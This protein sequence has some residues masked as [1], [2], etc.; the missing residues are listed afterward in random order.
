MGGKNICGYLSIWNI[1]QRLEEY[2]IFNKLN[3]IKNLQQLTIHKK[4]AKIH[5]KVHTLNPTCI[6]SRLDPTHNIKLIRRINILLRPSIYPELS[7]RAQTRLFLL[8]YSKPIDIPQ[9][10]SMGRWVPSECH[11]ALWERYCHWCSAELDEQGWYFWVD[12]QR[13]NQGELDQFYDAW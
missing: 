9:I 6:K 1:R 13:T 3:K 2:P 7:H 10:F 8:L 4:I 5:P 11:C 12:W